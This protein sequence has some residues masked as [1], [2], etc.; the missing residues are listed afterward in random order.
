MA[1]NAGKSKIIGQFPGY[2][3]NRDPHDSPDVALDVT[4][5]TFHEPGKMNCRKGCKPIT[6]TNHST[7]LPDGTLDTEYDVVS[8]FPYKK[9]GVY[10][11]I[12]EDS[13]GNVRIGRTE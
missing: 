11:I 3:T 5:V 1:D 13:N 8:M 2:G 6:F 10:Y 4:N 9:A 12:H 7:T